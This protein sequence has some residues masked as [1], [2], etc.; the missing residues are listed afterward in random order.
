MVI[1]VVMIAAIILLQDVSSFPAL[2]AV[3]ILGVALAAAAVPED[4]P[5]VVT[6]RFS[7]YKDRNEALTVLSFRAKTIQV[8]LDKASSSLLNCRI[9]ISIVRGYTSVV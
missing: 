1:A 9:F 5:T 2:F 3:L 6:G 4:L 7:A 8:F